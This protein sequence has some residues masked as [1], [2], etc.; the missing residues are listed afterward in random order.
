MMQGILIKIALRTDEYMIK[1]SA[2]MLA[3]LQNIKSLHPKCGLIK[4][5]GVTGYIGAVALSTKPGWH[6]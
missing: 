6:K 4:V 1:K 2:Y 3:E 5:L